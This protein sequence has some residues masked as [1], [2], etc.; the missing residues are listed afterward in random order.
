M[1]TEETFTSAILP[2]GYHL[3][4]SALSSVAQIHE[5]SHVDG[6]VPVSADDQWYASLFDNPNDCDE[7]SAWLNTAYV[8]ANVSPVS[9]DTDDAHH[10][11]SFLVADIVRYIGMTENSGWLV[12]FLHAIVVGGAQYIQAHKYAPPDATA[13]IEAWDV[14]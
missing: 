10:V 14:L 5:H 2:N 4:M 13:F 1:Y 6:S 12:T 7:L 9:T 3:V 8:R 11:L